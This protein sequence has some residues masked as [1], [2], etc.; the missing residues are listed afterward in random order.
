MFYTHN[1]YACIE[2]TRE[3]IKLEKVNIKVQ[4]VPQSQAATNPYTPRK[5]D[6]EQKLTRAN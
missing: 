1:E 3:K 5:R 2:E 6:K 4:G